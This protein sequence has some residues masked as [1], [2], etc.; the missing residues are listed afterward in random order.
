MENLS[1][2]KQFAVITSWRVSW[3]KKHD[4]V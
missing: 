1:N 3:G 4:P 2:K